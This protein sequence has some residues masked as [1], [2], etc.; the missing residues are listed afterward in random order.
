MTLKELEI[1]SRRLHGL[2]QGLA[3]QIPSWTGATARSA[4]DGVKKILAQKAEVDNQIYK[5]KHI[6]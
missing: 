2:A 1:E 5:I 4:R 3:A 6:A